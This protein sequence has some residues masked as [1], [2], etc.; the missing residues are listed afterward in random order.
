MNLLLARPEEVESPHLI[1]LVGSR[2]DHLVDVLD[3]RVGSSIRIGFPDGP[4]GEGVVESVGDSVVLR[5][6]LD[7]AGKPSTT[8]PLIH[9]LLA[10][11]RPKV[12]GRVL[13]H[14]AALGVASICLVRS[15]H[16]E[17]SYFQSD[18]LEEENLRLALLEGL[19]QACDTRIPKL[20]IY[21]LFRPFVEDS[22]DSL[23]PQSNR[24]LAHPYDSIPMSRVSLVDSQE[25]TIAI[26]PERGWTPFECELL[27]THGFSAVNLGPRVL[28]VETALTTLVA[29]VQLLQQLGSDQF[30]LED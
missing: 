14:L 9:I 13:S 27:G 5:H 1:R 11:P 16:V 12:L 3:V 17:K 25:T 6:N 19:E 29:Q 15:W 24:L 26:G 2:R 7:P 22:M 18:L 4:Q 10:M 30:G 23:W 28:R 8:L 21:R 20:E